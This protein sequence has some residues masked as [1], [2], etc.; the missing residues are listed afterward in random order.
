[1]VGALLSL[2]INESVVTGTLLSI[3]QGK[4]ILLFELEGSVV[5]P[6]LL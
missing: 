4:K 1:V 2:L 6:L 3:I 5:V